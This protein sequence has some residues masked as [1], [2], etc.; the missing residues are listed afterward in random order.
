[1]LPR[2]IDILLSVKTCLSV[3]FDSV[4]FKYFKVEIKINI[5]LALELHKINGKHGSN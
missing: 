4:V 5:L 1:M 2:N 3:I